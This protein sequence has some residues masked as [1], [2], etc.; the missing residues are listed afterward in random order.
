MKKTLIS[1]L[2]FSLAAAVAAWAAPQTMSHEGRPS[3]LPHASADKTKAPQPAGAEGAIPHVTTDGGNGQRQ[4]PHISSKAGG[5][6]LDAYIETL[7]AMGRQ[8]APDTL[9]K[10]LEEM[11]G[12][13]KRALAA[14]E[15]DAIFFYR[16]NRLLA[17]TKLVA[18]PDPSGVLVPVIEDVLGDYVQDKLGEDKFRHAKGPQAI[19]HVASALSTE[20]INLQIYLMTAGERDGLQRK[21]DAAMS[22]GSRK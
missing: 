6:L 22:G 18:V 3:V 4:V 15:I 9:D 11:M 17:V 20:L 5:A 19:S 13:A 2:I 7:S 8:G 10:R 21:I 12:A 14:K 16:F 1:C